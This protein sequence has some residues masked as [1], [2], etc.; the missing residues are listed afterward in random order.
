M[1]HQKLLENKLKEK[2]NN[3][4]SLA[5]GDINE[6]YKIETA[7]NSYVLKLNRE[8][9]FPEMF[10]KERKGLI[11]IV[12]AN[13]RSPKVIDCFNDSGFQFL[14]LE[15]IKEE[16]ITNV[17]WVNFAKSLAK[18]HKKQNVFYGLEYDNYIGSLNQINTPKKTWET[19]F[20]ENRLEPFVKKSF[21]LKLLQHN[22]LNSFKNL[23]NSLSEI[24]PKEN[25][26][27][28]HGD[29]WSG[30][31]I[32]GKDQTPYF[33]DPAIYFGNREMDIA[34]TQLFSGFDN[35]YLNYYNEIYPLEKGWKERINIHNLYPRLVHLIL[36]GNSY[37]SGIEN[38]LK[39]F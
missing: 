27:L 9:S 4:S 38:V 33:I 18:L 12:E 32:C 29:L 37:L 36:F 6:V 7:K 30:N 1:K 31:F 8:N 2:I 39:K 24:L 35:F 22:H 26:S 19:F 25:P 17:F 3:I 21:D 14:I 16:N 10:K 11:S 34:M 15:F 20:I 13:A 28:V 23:Y 5:G